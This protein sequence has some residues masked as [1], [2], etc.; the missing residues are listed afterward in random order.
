MLQNSFFLNKYNSS[1]KSVIQ[2]LEGFSFLSYVTSVI[3]V[4]IPFKNINYKVISRDL[5]PLLQVKAFTSSRSLSKG[6]LKKNGL[7]YPYISLLKKFVQIQ[8]NVPFVHSFFLNIFYVQNDRRGAVVVMQNNFLFK[9][10]LGNLVVFDF[11]RTTLLSKLYKL[12]QFVYSVISELQNGFLFRFKFHEVLLRSF[13]ITSMLDEKTDQQAFIF[14]FF[15]F[16]GEFNTLNEPLILD[17]FFQKKMTK[18][19]FENKLFFIQVLSFFGFFFS[20][21]FSK[22]FSNKFFIKLI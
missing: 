20:N 17:L 22:Q 18:S 12:N 21:Q 13:F 5:F 2:F 4:E 11:F 7:T 3:N 10:L 9:K 14:K 6:F 1:E 15:Q 8:H 16:L 19:V